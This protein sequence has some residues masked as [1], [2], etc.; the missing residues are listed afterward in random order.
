MGFTMNLSTVSKKLVDAAICVLAVLP[1]TVLG[2]GGIAVEIKGRVTNELTEDEYRAVEIVVTDRLDV[3]LGR[4]RP[5]NRGRYELK[6][7]APKYIIL[8]ALLEGYPTALY[9]LDTK[10]YRESTDDREENRVFGNM[11]IQTYYQNVTFGQQGSIPAEAERPLTLDGLL[12]REDPKAV[13][14]YRKARSQKEA[15]NIEKAVD[16]LRTLIKKYPYFYIGYVDLGMIL[17]AQQ[18][19]DQAIEIF[20]GARAL[21]PEQSWAYVGLGMAFNAKGEHQS[22]VEPLSKAIEIDPNSV[23][24]Q[25][26]LGQ[27]SFKLGESDQALA[28]FEKVVELDPKFDPMAYKIMSSLYVS[29]QD[30]QGAAGALEAYLEHFPEAPD[31]PKVE[32]I[33]AKLGR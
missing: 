3:E 13:K 21:R 27:A 1:I 25:F 8:K 15:G 4:T 12:A 14:V 26:Q 16:S 28:C 31:R 11:R 32:Q 19:N 2:Q 24:A 17:A 5:N 18:E 23:N 29:K 30:A 7:N 6:I 20:T 22:A 9:Q 33:L 10:E